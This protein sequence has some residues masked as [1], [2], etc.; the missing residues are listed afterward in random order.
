MGILSTRF[1]APLLM[2]HTFSDAKVGDSLKHPHYGECS[3]AL[4]GPDLIAIMNQRGN[5]AYFYCSEFDLLGFELLPAPMKTIIGKSV[6]TG[7][8][9]TAPP[10]STL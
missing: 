2:L 9:P 8:A 5:M 6:T 10:P 1:R 4:R 3:V 7:I